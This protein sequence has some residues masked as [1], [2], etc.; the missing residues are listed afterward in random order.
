VPCLVGFKSARPRSPG[1]PPRR[2]G[3]TYETLTSEDTYDWQSYAC[4]RSLYRFR[5]HLL[6]S[7]CKCGP[8]RR[9][10][11]HARRDYQRPLR[12]NPDWAW[13]K[14]WPNFFYW[15]TFR[16]IPDSV[17]RSCFL[18]WAGTNECSGWPHGVPVGP[19]GLI[20]FRAERGPEPG[21]PVCA[22]AFGMPCA[23]EVS[24]FARKH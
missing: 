24:Y 18:L 8:V 13:N 15:W 16:S 4:F 21:R 3:F 20:E 11:E 6:S 23:S 12:K 7:A 22:L 10:L 9:N 5:N 17:G 1:V 19:D 2:R 14:S